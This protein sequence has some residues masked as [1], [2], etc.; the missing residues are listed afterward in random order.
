MNVSVLQR[1]GEVLLKKFLVPKQA[2]NA[3]ARNMIVFFQANDMAEPV[4]GAQLEIAELQR[5]HQLMKFGKKGKKTTS[6][7]APRAINYRF[8]INP[9]RGQYKFYYLTATKYF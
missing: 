8:R 7:R 3:N 5:K 9:N 6:L 2:T 4:G 1:A